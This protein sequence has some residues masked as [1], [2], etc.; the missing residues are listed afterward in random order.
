MVHHDHLLE[1]SFLAIF[2]TSIYLLLSFVILYW[3]LL[4]IWLQSHVKAI[5]ACRF[6]LLSEIKQVF[7]ESWSCWDNR[8]CSSPIWV[9]PLFTF[10]FFKLFIVGYELCFAFVRVRLGDQATKSLEIGCLSHVRL[11]TLAEYR[12]L[13]AKEV[14]LFAF[15]N[16]LTTIIVSILVLIDILVLSDYISI[17]VKLLDF[18]SSDLRVSIFRSFAIGPSRGF[19]CE[20]RV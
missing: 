17:L 15:G 18:N 10:R 20:F 12:F 11:S 14:V 16:R 2:E 6:D 4:S 3:R 7:I 8:C 9:V 5:K 19:S 1:E 13:L